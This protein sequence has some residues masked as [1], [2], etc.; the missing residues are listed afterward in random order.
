MQKDIQTVHFD[1]D[2]N[3]MDLVDEGLS[4]LEKF[5]DRIDRAEVY[6]KLEETS[7]QI[8]DKIV[9]I[10][11]HVPQATLF[12]KEGSKSFETAYSDALDSMIRQLRKHKEKQQ[13]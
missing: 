10:K 8:K 12:S 7:G 2:Q 5:H 1:A 11:I 4:R 13:P 6:L 3:L 9:E